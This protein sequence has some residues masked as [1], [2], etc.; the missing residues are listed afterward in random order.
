[1]SDEYI[2]QGGD[3]RRAPRRLLPPGDYFFTVSECLAPYLNS[4]ENWVLKISIVCEG[5]TI[6][7]APWSRSDHSQTQDNRD[8]IGEFLLCVNRAPVHAGEVVD[9]KKVIGAKG[10]CKLRQREGTDFNEVQFFYRP[11]EIKQPEPVRAAPPRPK[12]PDLDVEPDDIP[13]RARIYKDVRKSR[14]NRRVL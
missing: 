4:N 8:G 11:K 13:F 9:W 2:F 1:M 5:V 12:D 7:A 6:L 14:L 3:Q 10:K